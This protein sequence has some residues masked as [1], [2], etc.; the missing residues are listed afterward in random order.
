MISVEWISLYAVRERD[1]QKNKDDFSSNTHLWLVTTGGGGNNNLFP[2]WITAIT[3]FGIL[4]LET[5]FCHPRQCDLLAELVPNTWPVGTPRKLKRQVQM[6]RLSLVSAYKLGWSPSWRDNIAAG[7]S[8]EAPSKLT[9]RNWP[10]ERLSEVHPVLL[11]ES[12]NLTAGLGE[13][14][15]TI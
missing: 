14:G 3:F 13:R 10:S 1:I 5:Y 8:R 12:T 9:H 11:Y 2:H 15:R 4:D 6:Q 7:I